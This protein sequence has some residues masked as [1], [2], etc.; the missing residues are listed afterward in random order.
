MEKNFRV[1]R[2]IGTLW[3]VLAWIALIGGILSSLGVLLVGILGSGGFVLRFLQQEAGTMPGA[4]SVVGSI[5]G[6][7]I[8]LT[9]TIINFLIL[10]A[11]GEL[12]DLLLAIEKNTRQT[13]YLMQRGARI[14]S[15]HPASPP[16]PAT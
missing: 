7:I 15:D 12:I 9:V 3:K 1:L 4:V 11:V 10:Y 16:P 14:G 13:M 6:F 2:I 5:L 8:S